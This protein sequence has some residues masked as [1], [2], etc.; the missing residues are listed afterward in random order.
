MFVSDDLYSHRTNFLDWQDFACWSHKYAHWTKTREIVH[1]I[2]YVHGEEYFW[3]IQPCLMFHFF[4]IKLWRFSLFILGNAR[5]FF[6]ED[7]LSRVWLVV[8]CC[9]WRQQFYEATICMSNALRN[10]NH[11]VTINLWN[12]SVSLHKQHHIYVHHLFLQSIFTSVHKWVIH[13]NFF[14]QLSKSS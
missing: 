3:Y 2:A 4:G 9:M 5:N 8:Y 13:H 1:E 12:F 6:G 10:A 7:S 11:Y 14:V